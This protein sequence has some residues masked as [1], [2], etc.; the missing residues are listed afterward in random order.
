LAV[1]VNEARAI[2]GDKGRLIEAQ[3]SAMQGQLEHYLHRARI[4]AQR[5]S[6]VYRTPVS[7][8][9]SRIVR[10]MEKL[11]PATRITLEL[12]PGEILFAGER[13]DLEEI[14]GNLAENALKWS[15]SEVLVS[16][17]P[18]D[19]RDNHAAMFELAVEDD[20]PGIPEARARE[21]LKRGKR[22]D[23]TKPGTGLGLAIV[24]ELVH[25]YDGMLNLERSA[26]GG[27]KAT[28]RLRTA[29]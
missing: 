20:G 28:V 23:E 15:K 27:L 8:A 18:I 5:D 9:L 11:N 13:E 14:V 3:S 24:S 7:P 4:A 16:V 6:I 17:S 12:P 19:G 25:E 1:L 10:V 26:L 2:G 22:L 21:A 29:H